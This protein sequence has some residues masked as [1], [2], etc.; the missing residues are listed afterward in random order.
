ML[1]KKNS[2][3]N[4]NKE[5]IKGKEIENIMIGREFLK[6]EKMIFELSVGLD[7][8]SRKLNDFSMKLD[9]LYNVNKDFADRLNKIEDSLDKIT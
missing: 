3:I 1:N 7:E 5:V 2:I 4:D 6:L 8:M 9:I